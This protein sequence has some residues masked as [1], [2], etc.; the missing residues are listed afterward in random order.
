MW[1]IGSATRH[2]HARHVAAAA[3]TAVHYSIAASGLC[4]PLAAAQQASKAPSRCQPSFC[5]RLLRSA[6]MVKGQ[7]Q[8]IG[9]FGQAP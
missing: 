1:E 5:S 9:D 3:R 2:A 7:R 8:R 4:S 6:W